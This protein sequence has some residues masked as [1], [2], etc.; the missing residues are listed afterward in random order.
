MVVMLLGRLIIN[1][2][3]I[4]IIIIVIIILWKQEPPFK[5]CKFLHCWSLLWFHLLL[6]Q[7][8]A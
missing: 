5:K 2:T 8:F 1:D 6:T 7:A 4:N 3:V